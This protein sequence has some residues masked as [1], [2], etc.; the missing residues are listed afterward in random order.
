MTHA[1]GD[2]RWIPSDDT[3]AARLAMIRH[4]M[5]WNLKEAALA[6]GFPPGSWREWE[7][8]GRDPRGLAGIAERIAQRTG[9]DEYWLMTGKLQPG[10]PLRPGQV[11]SSPLLDATQHPQGKPAPRVDKP[12]D[13]LTAVA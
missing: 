13:Q 3:F 11:Q 7:L 12:V 2:H 9:A 8:R 5:G 10:D 4:Q 6:C 1:H